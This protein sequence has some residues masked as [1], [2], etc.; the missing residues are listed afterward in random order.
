MPYSTH[1][2]N[3]Q[4][5]ERGARG[6]DVVPVS[7]RRLHVRPERLRDGVAVRV[8]LHVRAQAVREALVAHQHLE[9]ADEVRRLQ[10]RFDLS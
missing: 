6:Q 4:P 9:H 8:R 1:K 3:R 2:I 10:V 7:E 5:T